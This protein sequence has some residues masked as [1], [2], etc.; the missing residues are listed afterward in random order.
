[1]RHTSWFKENL[2][3]IAAV[4]LPIAVAGM[5]LLA[6]ALPKVL[7][8]APRFAL[9]VS[10][11][12]HQPQHTSFGVN[13]QVESNRLQAEAFYSPNNQFF[14]HTR[15]YRY[16]PGN[17]VPERFDLV[18]PD[19]LRARLQAM[20]EDTDKQQTRLPLPLPAPLRDIELTTTITAPDGYRFRNDYRGGGGL[21][22][23]L[24]GMGSR[25]RVVA[26]EKG[27]RVIEL[28]ADLETLDR[29]SYHNVRFLGWVAVD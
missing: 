18:L 8:E 21:F 6:T 2:F 3:L 13:L 7:V 17:P 1:M 24:F 10:I 29:Y 20:A 19:D 12:Q 11:G 22:G 14:E 23:E 25:G 9:L 28:D 15:V 26:I 27:G 16:T 5:F 4:I